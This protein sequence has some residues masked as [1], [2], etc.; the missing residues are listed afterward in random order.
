MESMAA[1]EAAPLQIDPALISELDLDTFQVPYVYLEDEPYVHTRLL[2]G[3]TEYTYDC[4]FPVKGHSAVMP[5]AIAEVQADGRQPLVAE[6][7]KR[8]Y[9]YL[10]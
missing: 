9:V 3:E 4:S 5:A 2:V 6:R 7:G 8:Y 1:Q 10:A